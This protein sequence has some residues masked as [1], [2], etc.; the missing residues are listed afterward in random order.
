MTEWTLS[1]GIKVVFRPTEFK[2]D[3]ILMRG[4]SKGG[5]SQVK[6]EDLPSAQM[7]TYIVEMSGL[8]SFNATQ[9]EKALAGKTVSVEPSIGETTEQLIGSS[10]VKDLETMLQLM[11][12]YFTSPRRDEEAYET[13]I[14]I[15][16]NQVVNRDKNPKVTFS[17]SIQMMSSDHS[18]RTILMTSE[19]LSRR[20]RPAS[21]VKP[22]PVG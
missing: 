21:R 18:E 5:L 17:D 2:A 8:G 20:L 12:L 10:S 19:T 15:M 3:E 16:R 11:Y 9:L 14:S 13:F 1:N 4:F 6:T 22:S 7:A